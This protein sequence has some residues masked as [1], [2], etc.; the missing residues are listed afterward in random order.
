[1]FRFRRASVG[2]VVSAVLASAVMVLTPAGA[3][4]AESNGGTKVMPLG[5]SITDGYNV[6]GGYRTRLWQDLQNDAYMV[7]FVGSKNSGPTTLGDRD[8]EGHSGY[9]IDEID[10][11]LDTWMSAA[12][13]RTVLLHLGTNDMNQDYAVDQ[14]P[15]RLSAL[16]DKIRKDAPNA[17]IFVSTI[18]PFSDATKEARAQTYNAA[19]PGIVKSK[20][21]KVHLVDMRPTI[22]A[23]DLADGIHPTRAGYDK[24]ADVWYAA[25]KSVPGSIGVSGYDVA[26]DKTATASGTCATAEGAP[27]AVDGSLTTK[28]CGFVSNGEAWLQLDLGASLS[29]RRWIVRHSAAGGER[30]EWNTKDFSLQSSASAD[31]PWTDFDSVTGNTAAVTD[32]VVATATSARYWRLRVTAPTQ[33]TD[34]AARIYALELYVNPSNSADL[35][36]GKT[37]SASGTCGTGAE[38][39]KAVD[40]S[41]TTKWCGFVSNGEAWLKVDLGSALAVRRWIVRHSA[42]GGEKAE[43]NTKDFALQYAGSADGPWTQFDSVTGNTD[44]VTDR[45][46]TETTARYWRLRVTVPTQTTDKAARIYALELYD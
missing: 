13:P 46:A 21:S 5:D 34:K 18:I 36:K 22:T 10:K 17:D 28:W 40:G 44:A 26:R 24:M 12:A 16:I 29:I 39:D 41:L 38:A 42:A 32:R 37:A 45:I 9:R 19:I 7:D 35:A 30:A 33:T 20:D 25:L 27:K 6:S 4:A 8:H 43:W 1:M 2:A 3:S 23:S 15:A 11:N 14:A 31:G